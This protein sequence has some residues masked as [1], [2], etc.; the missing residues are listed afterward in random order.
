[1]MLAPSGT[2]P[3]LFGHP[4]GRPVPRPGGPFPRY[5]ITAEV[6]E[7]ATWFG[8]DWTAESPLWLRSTA[9]C[10]SPPLPPVCGP[11]GRRTTSHLRLHGHTRSFRK[12]WSGLD[13]SIISMVWN[14]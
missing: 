8:K 1:M 11:H 10:R 5:S 14:R 4:L 9:L 2:A 12:R 7:S 6:L 3:V 13:G